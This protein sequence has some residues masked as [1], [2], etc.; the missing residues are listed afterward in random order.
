MMIKNILLLA[1]ILGLTIATHLF[2]YKTIVRLFILTNPALRATFF[3]IIMLL[4]LSFMA[5]FFLL[6]WQ[7]NPWSVG[8]YVFSA[9]WMGLFINLLLAALL[10]WLILASVGFAGGKLNT[11]LIASGCLLMAVLLSAYGAWNVS[12][13][14]VKTIEFKF[15]NLPA[16]WENSRIVQLSDVHLGHFYNVADLKKLAS[17]VNAL[18][19][20]IIFITGDLFD[21]MIA[22]MARF[23]EPLNQLNAKKGVFFITGNQENYV[24]LQRALNLIMK[25]KIKLRHQRRRHLGSAH[26]YRKYTGNR[27]DY[28][29]P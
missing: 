5:S 10:S 25:T 12:H 19:P 23:A 18:S 4:S 14:R 16:S 8:F 13:P 9:T 21:G 26:A 29:K 17:R 27:G 1:T 11:K 15:E 24:G 28:S 7:E 2:F 3:V 22:K 6:R 20:D